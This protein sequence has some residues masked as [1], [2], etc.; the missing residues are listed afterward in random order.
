MNLEQAQSESKLKI[1]LKAAGFAL[2]AILAAQFV[3][4]FLLPKLT[5]M[6]ANAGLSDSQIYGTMNLARFLAHNGSLMV[7]AFISGVLLMEWR[8]QLWARYRK[9]ALAASVFV[10]NTTVLVALTSVILAA[11]LMTPAL[12]NK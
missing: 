8:F 3:N 10:V 12:M 2:P 4:L 11:V 1:Y 5:Y 7:L 6:Q 9:A